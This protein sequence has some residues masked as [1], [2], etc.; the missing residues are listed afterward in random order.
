MTTT[1]PKKELYLNEKQIEFLAAPQQIKV[2]LAG[3][4]FGKSTAAGVSSRQKMGALPRG[5]IFFASTTYNQILTKTL[6]AI[7]QMWNSMGLIDEKHYVVGRRPPRWFERPIAPPRKYQNV[8]SFLN[9]FCIELLSMDR[10]DLA[11]GGSYDGG[12]VDE[13][14]LL[15][16]TDWT[17]ILLP[18][19][20]GNRHVFRHHLH[21]NVNFYTSIP[22]KPSGYWVLGFEEKQNSEP[23]LYKVVEATAYD[24]IEVL[25]EEGIA[26]LEKEMSYLEF[27]VEVMNM[28]ITKLPDGFYHKFDDKKHIY[29]PTYEY[30]EAERGLTVTGRKD[31][32]KN[33]LIE[34]S[35]DFSGWFN[36][37]SCYQEK[38][39]VERCI[40]QF[41][42][43]GDE[44]VP[45]LVRKVMKH[46]EDHDFKFVRIWGEP[47]GH[48]K[49]PMG[50][51]IYETIA[52][53]FADGGWGC[54]I[55]VQPGRTN[56]HLERHQFV[57]EVLEETNL[58]YP[59]LRFSEDDCKDMVI[60]IQVTQINDKFEKV[61]TNEKNRNFPQE[62][63][64]HYTDTIDYYLIQKHGWKQFAINSS[65]GFA[66]FQ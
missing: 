53:I 49:N 55:A 41:H 65:P 47:R 24:N 54:E 50:E 64:P 12:E 44:K 45:E 61:K 8:I 43:K 37:C 29:K 23:D 46:F 40:K 22:W 30:G 63:A 36:C 28:R 38:E 66:G 56:N 57:N 18:S 17:K 1:R 20:R 6:P 3:R 39:N 59:K 11:R 35:F 4:G 60:A 34:L 62:H 14:A 32:K 25:G 16:E 7:E 51:T 10:P 19:V 48:D 52:R 5:K 42:V 33:E 2:L 21:H 26:L 31:I 9:G 58:L 15:D 27:Q 13:A